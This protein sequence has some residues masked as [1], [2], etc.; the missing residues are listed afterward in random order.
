MNNVITIYKIN[1]KFFTKT[2]YSIIEKIYYMNVIPNIICHTKEEVKI[3]DNLIWKYRNL[4]FIPHHT[5]Y[6]EWQISRKSILI[7]T[8]KKNY[9]LSLS[10]EI[11]FMSCRVFTPTL[12]KKNRNF[13]IDYN[14]LNINKLKFRYNNQKLLFQLFEQNDRGKWKEYN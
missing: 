12:I 6:D 13:L 10:K 1:K 8:Y 7:S 4:L 9:N 3:L 5:Q 2:I 14:M 11:I